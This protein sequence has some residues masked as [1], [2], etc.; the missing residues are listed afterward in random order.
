[1]K[2]FYKNKK[3]LVTGGTGLI[4]RQL[5]NILQSYEAK[6][7][8]VSLDTP[9]GL[10]RRIKFIKM[11]LR[12]FD[13]CLKICKNIDFRKSQ[14]RFRKMIFEISTVFECPYLENC[15]GKVV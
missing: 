5:V 10:D 9:H 1:M 4:G 6:L 14:S 12:N 2:K 3:I 15:R 11:D 7:T 13:N 8:V